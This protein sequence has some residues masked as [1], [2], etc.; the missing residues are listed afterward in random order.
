MNYGPLVDL[1][2]RARH[3]DGLFAFLDAANDNNNKLSLLLYSR[4]HIYSQI[5]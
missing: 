5:L 3:C 4:Y 1:R 2:A